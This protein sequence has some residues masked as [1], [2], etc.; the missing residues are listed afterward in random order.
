M[1]DLVIVAFSDEATAFEARAELVRLQ[2]DYLV[3]MEDAV[4]VT[5]NEAGEV[6][7]HQAVNMTAAG[8]VGGG[9]WG[10]LI[11]LLFLNPLLG[12][13][14]GAGAG[15]LS[16]ALVDVGINDDF[17]KDVGKSL[18]KGQSAVA[19][20]IRKM[21]ADKLLARLDKFRAKGRVI[22]TSLTDE[23]EAKLKAVLEKAESLGA[24]DPQLGGNTRAKA[25]A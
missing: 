2:K 18:D 24:A 4:V 12:A 1:S 15:A 25:G 13:A 19:V 17:L 5:R 21:T 9:M 6:K 22:Q 23:M 8:A 20:L 16:G 3:E 11:G 7:L 10:M 14:A